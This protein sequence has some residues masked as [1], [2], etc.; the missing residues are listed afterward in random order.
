MRVRRVIATSAILGTIAVGAVAL[1]PGD[2]PS[3]LRPEGAAA[4]DA[5]TL[6]RGAQPFPGVLYGWG[7]ITDFWA[8]CL[9]NYGNGTCYSYEAR[10][11][12]MFVHSNWR[13]ARCR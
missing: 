10:F 1:A 2:A 11:F 9:I 4:I 12:G 3:G 8:A 5:Y 13:T 7:A 6:C